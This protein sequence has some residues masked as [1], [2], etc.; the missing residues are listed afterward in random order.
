MRI[1]ARLAASCQGYPS[2]IKI[3]ICFFAVW[4]GSASITLSC[5]T[6]CPCSSLLSQVLTPRL[7]SVRWDEEGGGTRLHNRFIRHRTARAR[8]T[9]ERFGHEDIWL[10][11][12]IGIWHY[13]HNHIALLLV[14]L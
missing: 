13:A 14:K 2:C 5:F 7:V 11:E 6:P 1:P 12:P 4:R 8:S 3:I 9:D 10:A